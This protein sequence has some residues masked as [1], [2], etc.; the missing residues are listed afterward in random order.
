MSLYDRFF[1]S[2]CHANIAVEDYDFI[3]TLIDEASEHLEK[4]REHSWKLFSEDKFKPNK[5]ET[6]VKRTIGFW[7]EE[8]VNEVDISCDN[9][10]RFRKTKLSE[11][12]TV[13]VN[14]IKKT[15]ANLFVM[16]H[17]LYELNIRPLRNFFFPEDNDLIYDRVVLS[18]LPPGIRNIRFKKRLVK[19]LSGS[20]IHEQLQKLPIEERNF[21]EKVLRDSIKNL[22][23]DI[24]KSPFFV[25]VGHKVVFDLVL[26]DRGKLSDEQ[27]QTS[28]T[29]FR[30][31]ILG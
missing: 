18:M 16:K 30:K 26:N 10:K 17:I 14:K 28:D 21:Y 4:L 9:L 12:L 8:S 6:L 24:K 19:K 22:E 23:D 15:R 7:Q 13:L 31:G 25:K 20:K 1:L 11:T 5:L 2:P 29:F 3:C 27:T